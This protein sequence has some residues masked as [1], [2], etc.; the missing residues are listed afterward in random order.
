MRIQQL[1]MST[2]SQIL[3]LHADRGSDAPW[4]AYPTS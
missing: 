2:K 3:C 4:E 1:A